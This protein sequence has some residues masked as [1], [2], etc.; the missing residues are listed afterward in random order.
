MS[1]QI[2][3]QDYKL[4]INDLKEKN[5]KVDAVITDPPYNVS[6]DYQLGFSNMGRSGMDYG[7]WDYNFNQTEWIK[8]VAEIVKPGGTMIIFNDW[9]NFGDI[10]KE[11]ENDEFIVKDLIRW[12]KKN[13]MPRNVERRYVTDY[14][15]AI[16][17]VKKGKKW[18]FNKPEDVGYLKPV[19]STGI[20]PGGKK[21]LHPTQKHLEVFEQ[22][23]KIHTNEGDTVLDPFLGSGT[24]AVACIK[25]NR[26]IIG[27]EIDEKYYKRAIGRLE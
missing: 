11:L 24:T 3:N 4:L 23:V 9:K 17:A 5:I 7:K 10:A 6:R 19:I 16:W 21:R 20:V 15:L 1:C 27:T 14:E 8:E 18:T 12:E 26:N 2:Y 22:L 13:P 25:N